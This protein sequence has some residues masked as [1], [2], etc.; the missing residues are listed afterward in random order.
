MK[1]RQM[2]IIFLFCFCEYIRTEDTERGEEAEK[3]NDVGSM[4]LF[5]ILFNA[6]V[7]YKYKKTTLLY[8]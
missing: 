7:L 3:G 2:V 8:F 5:C 4:R 6:C 1:L